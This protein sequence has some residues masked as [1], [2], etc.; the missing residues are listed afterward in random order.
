MAKEP[1][2]KK[3]A[4]I[5]QANK[6]MFMV[7]AAASVVLGVSIVGAIYLG[8]LISFNAKVIGEKGK[9]IDDYNTSLKNLPTLN[10]T[11]V[12][13]AEN[14]NLEVVGR[15]REVQC[16]AIEGNVNELFVDVESLRECSALRV[17]P[18]ALPA[19]R[20]TEALLASLNKVFI[21]AGINPEQLS[22]SDSSGSSPVDGVDIIPVKLSVAGDSSA[23]RSLLDSIERSIRTFEMTTVSIEW[24]NNGAILLSGQAHAFFSSEI[25]AEF[26]T[27]IVNADDSTG[28]KKK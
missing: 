4:L 2:I 20:N 12:E 1:A 28:G 11:V 10:S 24:R 13:L 7:V 16:E 8:K 23:V 19:T 5:D 9:I 18:D 15:K 22:P 6:N 27:K 3:R 21:T 14:E 25:S 26:K 17:I